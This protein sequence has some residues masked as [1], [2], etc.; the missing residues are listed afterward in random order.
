MPDQRRGD[1]QQLQALADSRKQQRCSLTLKKVSITIGEGN[2]SKRKTKKIDNSKCF[3]TI[4]GKS[5]GELLG[6]LAEGRKRGR[7]KTQDPPLPTLEQPEEPEAPHL[8]QRKLEVSKSKQNK[9]VECAN[10][11][12]KITCADPSK[13]ITR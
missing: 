3:L 13:S 9:Q 6:E 8:L 2:I 7:Q 10:C 5:I 12:K 11:Q 4:A 1:L